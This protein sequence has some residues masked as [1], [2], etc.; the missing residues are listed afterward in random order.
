M[1]R[2]R[3]LLLLIFFSFL[4]APGI[5][6][7]AQQLPLALTTDPPADKA[8]PAAMDTMRIPSHGVDLNALMYVAA[9]AGPHPTVVLLNGLPGNERNLDLAQAIRRDGWNVLSFNYRGSEGSSGVFSL[10]HCTEDTAAVLAF[11]R[12]PGYAAELRTDP[13]R[14]VLVGHSTGGFLA[15][16]AA[17][18]DSSILAL[19]IISAAHLSAMGNPDRYA[20]RLATRPVLVI[21]SDDGLATQGQAFANALRRHGETHLIEKHFAADHGYSGARI[22]LTVAVLN[23]LESLPD[24][25]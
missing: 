6:L 10:A 2:I 24:R 15:T 21:T 17:A 19:A 5:P 16:Y 11:L 14:I 20:S 8:H 9:G 7:R 3:P 1:W 23:W 18:H 13:K 12:D 25:P 4:F 22:A